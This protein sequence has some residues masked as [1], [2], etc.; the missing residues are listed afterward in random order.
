MHKRKTNQKNSTNEHALQMQSQSNEPM[1]M[2]D[3]RT[4]I[5]FVVIFTFLKK[6]L[7]G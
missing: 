6:K 1:V 3:S 2:K 7:L 4:I 5:V